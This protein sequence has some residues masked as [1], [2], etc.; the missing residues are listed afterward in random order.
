MLP[1]QYSL[2][3]FDD[4]ASECEFHLC[5]VTTACTLVVSALQVM[6]KQ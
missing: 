4:T 5:L 1:G 2:H 3:N 6:W